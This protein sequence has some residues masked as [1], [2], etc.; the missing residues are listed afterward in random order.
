MEWIAFARYLP[1]AFEQQRHQ[2]ATDMARSAKH[3]P[4]PVFLFHGSIFSLSVA[5]SLYFDYPLT[6]F[7]H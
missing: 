3:Q 2:A 6:H 5:C 7:A 4:R 1:A